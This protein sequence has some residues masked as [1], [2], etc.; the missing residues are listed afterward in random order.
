MNSFLY[1]F[2]ITIYLMKYQQSTLQLL[3][4]VL[5]A[6]V[7]LSSALV[8]DKRSVDIITEDQYYLPSRTYDYYHKRD[9]NELHNTGGSKTTTTITTTS[10]STSTSKPTKTPAPTSSP[11]SRPGMTSSLLFFKHFVYF[12][13]K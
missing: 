13:I 6:V 10:T 7:T 11:S 1:P 8:I 3:F 4:I 5:L 2:P 12:M 9:L